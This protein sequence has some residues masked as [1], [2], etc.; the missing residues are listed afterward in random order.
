TI[1]HMVGSIN[2]SVI[3]PASSRVTHFYPLILNEALL[4]ENAKANIRLPAQLPQRVTVRGYVAPDREH[5]IQ[6]WP[7]GD[8]TGVVAQH[9]YEL[10]RTVIDFEE[11]GPPLGVPAEAVEAERVR[12]AR[13]AASIDRAAYG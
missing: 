10:G 9:Q 6:G 8:Y 4:E 11:S 2:L 13:T 3:G 7:G 5:T 1:Q 12:V